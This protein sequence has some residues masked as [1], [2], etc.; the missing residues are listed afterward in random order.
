MEQK[1]WVGVDTHKETLAYYQNGKFKE[2]KTTVNGFKK[3]LE[4]AL[5]GL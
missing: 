3:A 5:I 4:W 2:F 1:N